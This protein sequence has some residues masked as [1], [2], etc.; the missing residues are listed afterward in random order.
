MAQ[1]VV[2][3]I[4]SLNNHESLALIG[5]PNRKRHVFNLEAVTAVACDNGNVFFREVNGNETGGA[6][7]G[8]GDT[9]PGRLNVG[10]R[11]GSLTILSPALHDAQAPA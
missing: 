5:E 11:A 7:A 9:I 3:G 8:V 1:R 4:V 2:A 10:F 6:F